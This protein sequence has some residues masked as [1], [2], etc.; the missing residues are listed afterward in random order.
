MATLWSSKYSTRVESRPGAPT[1]PIAERLFDSAEQTDPR[2]PQ[3]LD[4]PAN[5]DIEIA[6]AKNA[7]AL[8]YFLAT[9]VNDNQIVNGEDGYPKPYLTQTPE[10]D[11]DNSGG[12]PSLRRG[13]LDLPFDKPQNQPLRL[14]PRD[15]FGRWP[16]P[17][18]GAFLSLYLSFERIVEN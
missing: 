3:T 1:V 6:L 15:M 8:T 9:G 14:Y 7:S 13:P 10:P 4:G 16:A 5:A 11:A 17:D 18:D 2:R 12:Q